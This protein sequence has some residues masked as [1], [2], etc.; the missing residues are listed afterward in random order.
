VATS[1]EAFFSANEVAVVR[2]SVAFCGDVEIAREAA[3]EAFA[4]AFARWGRLQNAEWAVGWVMTT[5]MN[6]CR[7]A[8]SRRSRRAR[9]PRAA[10]D[11]RSFESRAVDHLD[12]QA[13]LQGLPPRQRQ[14]AI[15]FYL[16]DLPVA[17]VAD[18]MQ[19]SEGAVKSHLSAAR[20]GLRTRLEPEVT[21]L[22]EGRGSR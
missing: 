21:S 13:A 10:E 9:T 14:A 7:R 2:A 11:A 18:A 6:Q 15:L 22:D 5:A 1:F 17:A 12:L 20:A 19:L 3:Q 16:A 8:A 4:R